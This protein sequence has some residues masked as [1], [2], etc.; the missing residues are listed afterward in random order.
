MESSEKVK[1]NINDVAF[2]TKACCKLSDQE[3]LNCSELFSNHYG[4]WG[5]KA[6]KPGQQIKLSKKSYEEYAKLDNCFVALAY[7]NNQLIGHAF[8]IRTAFNNNEYISWVIQLVVDSRYRQ[9]GIGKTLL[10]SI[11]G[12]SGDK[13]WGLATSNPYTVKTLESATFREVHPSTIAKNIDLVKQLGDLVPFARNKN[14]NVSNS[15]SIVNTEFYIDHKR[16]PKKIENAYKN[17]WKLG[18]LPD[19]YEWLAFTFQDQEPIF[20]EKQFEKLIEFSENQLKE[21]Y[22]RM[23]MKSQ[24]WTKRSPDEVSF[25]INKLRLSGN[26]KI[27]DFGCGIGRHCIEF[28]KLNYPKVIGFDFVKTNIDTA[29]ADAK[30]LDLNTVTFKEADCR[31]ISTKDSYLIIC[32]LKL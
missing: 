9:N 31:Y 1:V 18:D 8:Y 17:T 21:A 2:F 32:T 5:E 7:Y 16:I 26:E 13:A 14:Y 15:N 29:V 4:K 12:F 10:H 20:S 28:A 25:I 30:E 11:W 19:G 3:L 23:N 27:A 24:S 6:E 22:S